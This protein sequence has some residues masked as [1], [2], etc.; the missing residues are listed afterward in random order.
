MVHVRYKYGP[1][2][3][4]MCWA[5]CPGLIVL[6]AVVAL[7]GYSIQAKLKK[8]R[9]HEI[10][11]TSDYLRKVTGSSPRKLRTLWGL[12]HSFVFLELHMAELFNGDS[13]GSIGAQELQVGGR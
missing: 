10:E 8:K 4:F 3:Y 6:S 9:A 1:F 2:S 12:P 13:L 5:D 7:L 11:E